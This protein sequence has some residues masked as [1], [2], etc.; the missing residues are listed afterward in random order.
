MIAKAAKAGLSKSIDDVQEL[1]V[2]RHLGARVVTSDLGTIIGL[3]SLVRISGLHTCRESRQSPGFSG[4]SLSIG[5]RNFKFDYKRCRLHCHHH[6]TKASPWSTRER[7]DPLPPCPQALIRLVRFRAAMALL[8]LFST[9][10]RLH[11][12]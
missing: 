1:I 5:I 9:R 4:L 8:V 2:R 11:Q 10:Y 6:F 7:G 3:A 12:S